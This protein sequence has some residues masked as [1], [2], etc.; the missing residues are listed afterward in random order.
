MDAP[1]A[2]P[3]SPQEAPYVYAATDL[4]PRQT[5]EIELCEK[6]SHFDWQ[7]AGAFA[8]GFGAS[9]YLNID[10]LKHTTEPGLRLLGPGLIGF[11]WGGFLSGGYLSLPKC[12]PMWAY[13][14]PPEGNVRAQWPLATAI[15]IVSGV[16]APIM[17]YAFL[18]PVKIDWP[19]TERSARVFIAAGAG[20]LGS[21]FP[22]LLPPRTWAAAKEIERMRVEGMPGGAQL[23]YWRAF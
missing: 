4:R 19:V 22:Y 13:G 7:Y 21:L 10:K 9:I 2:L 15:A 20:V 23:S 8:V 16:T 18:G 5:R 1:D 12:D 17:D 14:P 6:A 11:T 3:P